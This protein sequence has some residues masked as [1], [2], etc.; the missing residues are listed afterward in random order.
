MPKEE[1]PFSERVG[2]RIS[3]ELKTRIQQA[4]DTHGY[5]SEADVVRAALW[6]Y[7]EQN[8]QVEN[9]LNQINQQNEALADTPKPS[10]IPNEPRH[11]RIEW[12]LT[13]IVILVSIVGSKILNAVR[14][15]KVKPADLADEAIQEAVYNWSILWKKLRI[16]RLTSL[17]LSDPTDDIKP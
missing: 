9:E 17:H 8:E 1:S 5:D 6:L 16:A 3:P 15:E 4:I 10:A 2:A 7:V 11:D 13:V 12:A 14:E